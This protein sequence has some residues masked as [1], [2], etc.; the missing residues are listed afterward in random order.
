MAAL[1]DSLASILFIVDIKDFSHHFEGNGVK[2]AAYVGYAFVGLALIALLALG[3][4]L[5]PRK[6]STSVVVSSSGLIS[7]FAYHL[8]LVKFFTDPSRGTY[9]A[10][11]M[12]GPLGALTVAFSLY[13]IYG[14]TNAASICMSVGYFIASSGTVYLVFV[15]AAYVGVYNVLIGTLSAG[16]VIQA[17]SLALCYFHR[18]NQIRRESVN[19]EIDA[20]V[21]VA[22]HP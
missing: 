13:G 9:Y 10:V 20:K 12:L 19:S 14:L 21:F 22:S 4:K 18:F 15:G 17:I 6:S 3:Y 11:R 7:H 8:T 2:I 5:L 16:L 1:I